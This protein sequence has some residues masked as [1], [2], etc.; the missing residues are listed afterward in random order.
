MGARCICVAGGTKKSD[1]WLLPQVA[2]NPA[3]KRDEWLK[4]PQ[5]DS[6]SHL[7]SV[8]KR[9]EGYADTVDGHQESLGERKTI[10]HAKP[11]ED[12]RLL[13]YGA[14]PSY[15]QGTP[16]PQRRLSLVQCHQTTGPS[17]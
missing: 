1:L 10:P 17:K 8:S 9:H 2:E 13:S 5:Q 12:F 15:H 7:L 14:S 3:E 16:R 6:I 11:A 4:H